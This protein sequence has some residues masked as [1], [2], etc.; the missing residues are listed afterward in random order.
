MDFKVSR[1]GL[2]SLLHFVAGESLSEDD[3]AEQRQNPNFDA[4]VADT[5]P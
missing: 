3:L 1:L 2:K 4:S 5:A